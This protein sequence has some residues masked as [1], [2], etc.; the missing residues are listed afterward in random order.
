MAAEESFHIM[1]LREELS[2][3]KDVMLAA[4]KEGP[5]KQTV[6]KHS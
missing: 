3:S 1:D 4:V 2:L 6:W 5:W